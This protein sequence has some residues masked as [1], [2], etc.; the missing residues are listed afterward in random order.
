MKK[1][2]PL[3]IGQTGR[4]K[5]ND[6]KIGGLLSHGAV[7]PGPDTSRTAINSS[8]Y[9]PRTADDTYIA[10]LVGWMPF[11]CR[12]ESE[13]VSTFTAKTLP[14]GKEERAVRLL[15]AVDACKW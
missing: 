4:I 14:V 1:L 10:L 3:L 11:C 6:D 9:T 12:S 15:S 2:S 13:Q 8:I 7:A 5:K